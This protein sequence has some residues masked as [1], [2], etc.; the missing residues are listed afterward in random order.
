[1]RNSVG[2]ISTDWSFEWLD[3]LTDGEPVNRIRFKPWVGNYVLYVGVMENGAW[4][5]T[6]RVPYNPNAE[7]AYPNGADILYTQK[8]IV[9]VSEDWFEIDLDRVYNADRI[10]LVFTNLQNFGRI[11]GGDYRAGVYEFQVMGYTPAGTTTETVDTTEEVVTQIPGNIDDYTD[12]IKLFLAWSGFYWADGEDD[13]LFLKEE[14]GSRGG[15][16]W[17]D[18]F[19]SGAYPVEPPCIPGSYWDNKSVMDAIN[20]VKET[21]GF[22]GYVDATGGFIWRPPNIWANGNYITGQGWVGEQSIP[23]VAE[24]TLLMDYGVVVDDQ[25]LRSEIVVVSA[26]DPTVYGSYTPGYAEGEEQPKSL[27]SSAAESSA[28]SDQVVTDLSLLAGQQRVMIVPD[29]P[30]GGVGEEIDPI[31]AR[32]EVE[33]FAFLVS[34]WIHWS[35]RKGKVRIPANP[36]LDVDDQIRI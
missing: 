27:E 11:S 18:F 32:A 14:W 22:L 3:A 19:Y 23:V 25:A 9:P 35:Y 20:Q 2:G 28:F 34:L 5:G 7:P 30:F 6:Q 24:N 29:Y 21:L 12:M 8:L 13:P 15:R 10:R 31:A 1:M 17:G 36:A 16:V 26:A 4:Q 33:K